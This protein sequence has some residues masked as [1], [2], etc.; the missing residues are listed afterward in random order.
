M[1]D[2]AETIA[3]L[4]ARVAE[5]EALLAVE[6]DRAT[7]DP[8]TGL[9]NRA[10][11][12]D[13]WAARR[14]APTGWMLALIDL[15]GFKAVND[16]YGHA[17][18]DEVLRAMAY[19]LRELPVAARLGGDEFVALVPDV[20]WLPTRVSATPRGG[21]TVSAGLSIGLTPAQG[22]LY[23]VLAKADAAMYYAKARGLHRETYDPYRHDRQVEPRPR[24]RLRDEPAVVALDA[25]RTAA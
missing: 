1:T 4:Q 21:P 10:G 7:R 15:D 22:D 19:W 6:R 2:H 9:L 24:V 20:G 8:L 11:F 14:P 23:D 13:D 17:A 3:H 12:A 18:G 5:L 16:R 25:T